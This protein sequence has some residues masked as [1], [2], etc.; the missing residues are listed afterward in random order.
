MNS[1]TGGQ[2]ILLE[3]F[4]VFAEHRRNREILFAMLEAIAVMVDSGSGEGFQDLCVKALS[5][6]IRYQRFQRTLGTFV[7]RPSP[8]SPKDA[9]VRL[10]LSAG[11]AGLGPLHIRRLQ[12][13]LWPVIDAGDGVASARAHAKNRNKWEHAQAAANRQQ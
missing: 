11:S 10:I 9:M 1:E 3:L 2:R 13:V 8:L 7:G 12:A 5:R 4:N 6:W